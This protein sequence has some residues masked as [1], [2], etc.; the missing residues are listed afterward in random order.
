M[1]VCCL[2][3]CVSFCSE[4]RVGQITSEEAR[5]LVRE[6]LTDEGY[7]TRTQRF[8]L[9][10]D[11]ERADF[12]GFYFLSASYEQEQSAPTLG[13]FAVNRRSADLWDW[14]LCKKLS[15]SSLRVSQKRLRKEMGLSERDY[16][17]VSRTAPCSG[18]T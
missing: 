3:T 14:E 18:P 12:P 8:I 15:S 11:R 2:L 17:K 6:W 13:H 5:D 10:S 16:R 7:P 9:D 1:A 4:G